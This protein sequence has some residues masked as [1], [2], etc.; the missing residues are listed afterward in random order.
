VRA[1]YEWYIYK[2]FF[3][4]QKLAFYLFDSLVGSRFI[5]R[6]ICGIRN[7]TLIIDLPSPRKNNCIAAIADM[8]Q[9]TLCLLHGNENLNIFDTACFSDNNSPEQVKY[10]LC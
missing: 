4:L 5:F 9:S 10:Y 1:C 7:E 2:M 6:I 3:S 8:L